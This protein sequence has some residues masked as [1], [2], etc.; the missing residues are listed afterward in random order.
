MAG[1][2]G[3]RGRELERV[4]R[5]FLLAAGLSVYCYRKWDKGKTFGWGFVF[6]LVRE[7]VDMRGRLKGAS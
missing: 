3:I 2:E 7:A 5:S 6:L 1:P 4:E